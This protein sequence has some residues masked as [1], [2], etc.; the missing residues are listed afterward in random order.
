[1][2]LKARVL[3]VQETAL[4]FVRK[5]WRPLICVGFLASVWVNLVIIPWRKGEPIEFDK[6]AA[7]VTA[8]VAAFAVREWGKAKGTAD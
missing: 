1:V 7:F 4:C 8:I 3:R 2:S 5:W 6:A